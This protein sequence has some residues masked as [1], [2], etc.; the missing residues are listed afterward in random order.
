MK[1]RD[2][3]K[4]TN[5]QRE[6]IGEIGSYIVYWHIHGVFW[7]YEKCIDGNGISNQQYPTLSNNRVVNTQVYIATS[8]KLAAIKHG[9]VRP[10]EI[11]KPNHLPSLSDLKGKQS[12][13]G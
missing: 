1:L 6:A 4:I 10:M 11:L 5:N 8:W 3:G 9:D 12:T 7:A 13:V 2:A